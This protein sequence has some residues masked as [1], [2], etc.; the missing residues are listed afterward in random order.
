MGIFVLRLSRPI[1]TTAAARSFSSAVSL[2]STSSTFLRQSEMS[3]EAV[4]CSR[5]AVR[6]WL[7]SHRSKSKSSGQLRIFDKSEKLTANSEKRPYKFCHSRGFPS[8]ILFDG[9]DNRAAHNRA[10]S[11]LAD[12]GELLGSG[13]SEAHGDG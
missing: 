10:L 6:A 3:I 7:L 1:S 4:R 8:R 12:G 2:T 5:L 9:M 11:V 13:N